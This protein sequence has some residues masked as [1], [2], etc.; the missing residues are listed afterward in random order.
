MIAKQLLKH[1]LDRHIVDEWLQRAM[2]TNTFSMLVVVV[3]V[4]RQGPFG[5]VER[6][7]GAQW[8]RHR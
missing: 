3:T 7:A 8:H 1:R 5:W 2:P 4:L 6:D